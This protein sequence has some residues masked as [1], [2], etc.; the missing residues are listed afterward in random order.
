[1]GA[2]SQTVD[3]R[4]EHESRNNQN[5]PALSQAEYDQVGMLVKVGPT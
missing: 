4:E 2:A 1:M 5:M 3:Q